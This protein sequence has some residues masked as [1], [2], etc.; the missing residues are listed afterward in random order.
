ML[1]IVFIV[2]IC[3]PVCDVIDFQF[4][5]S[6]LI[7]PFSHMIKKPGQKFEYFKNEKCF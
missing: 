5:L 7:K 6:F 4:N 3:L 1:G 2:I